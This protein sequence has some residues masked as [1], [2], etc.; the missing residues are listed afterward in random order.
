MNP[1]DLGAIL[2]PAGWLLLGPGQT[3][4]LEAAAISRTADWPRS[5]AHGTIR[6][7]SGRRS[8]RQLSLSRQ[9]CVRRRCFRCPELPAGAIATSFRLALTTATATSSGTRPSP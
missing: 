7:G 4:K 8:A 5:P 6:I 1:V 9:A 3:A 2:V